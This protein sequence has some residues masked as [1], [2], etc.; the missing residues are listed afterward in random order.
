MIKEIV[1]KIFGIKQNVTVT[2]TNH[3]ELDRA[4]D[5]E[6]GRLLGDALKEK[7]RAEEL[8][9]QLNQVQSDNVKES[10][11]R[12]N[13]KK[14]ELSK[15]NL[16]GGC[17]W[18]TLFDMVNKKKLK[19]RVVSFDMDREFGL[20]DRLIT[21]SRGMINMFVKEKDGSIRRVISGA[22]FSSIFRFPYGIS[23]M[24]SRGIFIINLNKEGEH[25]SDPLHAEIPDLVED[26]NGKYD[27][28]QVDSEPFIDRYVKVQSELA[29]AHSRIETLE[30]TMA[31]K[32]RKENMVRHQLN[33][34][35]SRADTSESELSSNIQKIT[36][37]N[38]SYSSAVGRIA[39]LSQQLDIMTKQNER[40]EDGMEQ[41]MDKLIEVKKKT[42]MEEAKD[43]IEETIMMVDK[44]R[45]ESQVV[46]VESNSSKFDENMQKLA[47][48]GKNIPKV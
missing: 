22:K 37:I 4:V 19:I 48:Q 8:A 30:K 16:D 41:V 9:N 28:S 12:L 47:Q 43:I 33:V 31:E 5:Y 1:A 10:A 3:Q 25:V 46:N 26:A 15:G 7:K 29:D 32:I 20:F 14:E 44:F 39:N 21:D 18:R 45:P 11:T 24:A 36:E 42:G 17:D 2:P 35:K 40:Y 34:A 38:Q 13:L 27:L 23:K 6:R